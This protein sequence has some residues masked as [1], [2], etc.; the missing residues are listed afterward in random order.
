MWI[1]SCVS[2]L[3]NIS[4]QLKIQR[5]D[6]RVLVR[7]VQVWKWQ[8]CGKG[9]KIVWISSSFIS[10]VMSLRVVSVCKKNQ[11]LCNNQHFIGSQNRNRL[12]SGFE[13][14]FNFFVFVLAKFYMQFSHDYKSCCEC[15][16]SSFKLKIY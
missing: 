12:F 9:T 11:K 7:F 14:G 13:I 1:G 6:W 8:E 3:V 4:E 2:E 5:D 15:W 16:N 10:V